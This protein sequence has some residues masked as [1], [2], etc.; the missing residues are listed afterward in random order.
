MIKK[1]QIVLFQPRFIGLFIKENIFKSLLMLFLTIIIAIIPGAITELRTQEISTQFRTELLYNIEHSNIENAKIED[2]VLLYE[3]QQIIGYTYF[4][5]IIGGELS[6]D[7]MYYYNLVFHETNLKFYISNIEVYSIEYKELELNNIDFSLVNTTSATESNKYVYIFNQLYND[8]KI[9]INTY[10]IVFYFFEVLAMI[11][12]GALVMA[13]FSLIFNNFGNIMPFKYRYKICLNCQ[14]VYIVSIF[15]SFLYYASWMQ[16]VG[17]FVMAIY[18]VI[19]TNSIR[20][21]KGR[22]K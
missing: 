18:V 10:N 4:N 11:F 8:N 6:I 19:A 9:I 13:C 22:V 1:I 14:Y 3:E 15:L 21:E 17:N 12:I 5:V 20:M 16:L 7:N 2:G